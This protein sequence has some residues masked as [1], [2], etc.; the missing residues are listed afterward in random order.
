MLEDLVKVNFNL[1]YYKIIQLGKEQKA[2]NMGE[3]LLN[4]G[5]I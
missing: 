4:G 5:I 1:L 2:D 3:E